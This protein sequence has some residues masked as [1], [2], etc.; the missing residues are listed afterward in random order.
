MVAIGSLPMQEAR[1]RFIETVRRNPVTVVQAP[2]GAGKT[3]LAPLMLLEAGFGDAGMIGVTQ[4]RRIAALSVSRYVAELH[5]SELGDVIGYQI[6]GESMVHRRTRAKFMT[7]GILLRELAS[8]PY[9]RRYQVI[10]IDEAHERSVNQDL[11]IAI[12]RGLLRR[13]TDLKVIIMSATIDAAKF[14]VHFDG[15]PVIRVE[16]RQFPVEVRYLKQTPWSLKELLRVCAEMVQRIVTQDEPGDVLAFLPDE[17]TIRGTA[18]L[19][20]K[21]WLRG[22][23]ILPLFGAQNPDEQRRAFQRTSDQRIILATNIAET[24]LTID[25]VVHVVDSG[26]VKQMQYAGEGMSALT[27]VPHAKAGCVQREGRAGR[28]RAGICHRLYT[29]ADFAERPDFTKPEIQRTALDQTLLHLRVLGHS[30]EEVQALEFMDA[31]ER[32]QWDDAE[33]R[34]HVLGGLDAQ[35][36]VTEDGKRM[37]R[38]PVAP[39]LGRMLLEAARRGCVQEIATVVAGYMARPVFLKGKTPEEQGTYDAMHAEFRDEQSD[40]LTLL[41]VWDAWGAAGENGARDAWA[42]EQ[43]LSFRA[44]RDIERE[45]EHLLG[46]LEALDVPTSSCADPVA[47]RKAV[48]AGCIM[49]L[50]LA[51]GEYNYAWHDRQDVFIHPSSV[52]FAR[53]RR[54]QLMVCTE[55]VETS[56]AFARNCTEIAATWVPELLP[57]HLLERTWECVE[58]TYGTGKTQVEERVQWQGLE[59]SRRVVDEFPPEVIPVIA[60]AILNKMLDRGRVMIHPHVFHLVQMWD[61]VRIVVGMGWVYRVDAATLQLYPVLAKVRELLLQRLAGAKTIAEVQQRDLRIAVE[62]VLTLEQYA[63]HEE[64]LVA[65]R[66]RA[67]A[68]QRLYEAEQRQREG[69]QR[70]REKELRPLRARAAAL[71]ERLE[72]LTGDE[73]ESTRYRLSES[74]RRLGYALTSMADADHELVGLEARVARLESEQ[75]DS[76]ALSELGWKAVLDVFPVCPL[77]GGAWNSSP[78]SSRHLQCTREHDVRRVVVPTVS[79]RDVTTLLAKFLTNRDEEVAKVVLLSTGMVWIDF[80]R[81]RTHAWAGKKFKGVREE[82]CAAI[83]PSELAPHRDAILGDLEELRRSREEVAALAA[84]V[85]ELEAR[86][87]KVERLTFHVEGGI[88]VADHGTAR[89]CAVFQDL[90]PAEGETWMC[91]V[92]K[93]RGLG[94]R[95]LDAQPLFKVGSI[96]SADDLR[97]LDALLRETYPGLPESVVQM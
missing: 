53:E 23:R 76:I 22:C 25:G 3:T 94:K 55:V 78:H 89:Y 97:E 44:L 61:S 95:H 88:A 65:E 5:G 33:R 38:L 51:R 13:R 28:T 80:R 35:G 18:A 9:L 14:A 41:K 93:E 68:A 57:A 20:A 34:L 52:L 69:L 60:D 15:A 74:E 1:D 70:K 17:Q 58:D 32:A 87:G 46:V 12:I 81:A 56:R 45:R 63:L 64:R 77:C 6:K 47:V 39:M 19:I 59:L 71:R 37:E 30:M 16:G 92:G 31:P 62:D 10:V 73:V 27:I 83:L 36:A 48:A 49:N 90:Y 50:A 86:H 2:T 21:M 67:Q 54:A 8:D 43:H 7:E 4:P 84:R 66:E 29:R 24:S 26:L 75:Q 91:A 96:S 40:A 82:R 79:S 42:R 72:G 11:L 85:Q